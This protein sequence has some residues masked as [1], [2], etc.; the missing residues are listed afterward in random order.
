M[1]NDF[2]DNLAAEQYRKMHKEKKQVES[3]KREILE[4][5]A[6]I[7]VLKAFQK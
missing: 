6:E 4:L 2:L 1:N 7:A 5:Q 3:L